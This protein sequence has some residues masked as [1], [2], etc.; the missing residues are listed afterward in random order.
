[1]PSFNEFAVNGASVNGPGSASDTGST[2]TATASPI[3]ATEKVTA[4]DSGTTTATAATPLTAAE[5]VI[6]VEAG[7]ITDAA[8]T[9]ITA[10][11]KSIVLEPGSITAATATPL[12]AVR[13]T[14]ALQGRSADVENITLTPKTISLSFQSDRDNIDDCR[15][16][17]RAGDLNVNIGY[18]GAFRAI[19]RSSATP[20]AVEPPAADSPPFVQINGYVNGYQEEQVAPDRF[21]ISLTVHRTSNRD[22]EFAA[23]TETGD[24]EISLDH[25][26]VGL[27]ESQVEPLSAGGT[28]TGADVS[29]AL[30]LSDD[31]AAAMLD[32]L[33]YPD[34]IAERPI[35]DGD[36]TLVDENGRQTVTITSPRASSL[37]DGD[38]L[39]KR[40]TVRFRSYEPSRNWRMEL[41]MAEA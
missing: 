9:P 7:S 25:G 15:L 38:W 32:S 23:I 37:S 13:Q 40:W 20:T 11:E 41:T 39:V 5:S 1:M 16:Y 6:A 18:A 22:Q 2:T 33:G 17:E 24:W 30:A 19:A 12:V 26:T 21:E 34:A 36:D 4:L 35:P 29:L 8:A 10:T 14:W 27:N 31:Q 3:T 28:T